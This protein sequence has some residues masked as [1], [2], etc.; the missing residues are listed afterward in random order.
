[1]TIR[2]TPKI[3]TRLEAEDYRRF[4]GLAASKQMPMSQLARDAICFYLDHLDRGA[5]DARESQLELRI[6][7]MENRL[8]GLLA[9]ANIDIGVIMNLMYSRMNAQTRE[10]EIHVAHSKSVQRL[11]RKIETVENLKDLYVTD[12]K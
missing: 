7:K 8:A 1:M 11:K 12:G 10:E 2:E 9:R 6:K 5:N 4:M 3:V